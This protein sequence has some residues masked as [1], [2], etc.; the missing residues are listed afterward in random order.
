MRRQRGGVAV[1]GDARPRSRLQ[2]RPERALG[3][4]RHVDDHAQFLHPGQDAT[5]E[6]GEAAVGLLE[7]TVGEIVALIPRE[8]QDP[9][10]A[11]VEAV[12][13]RG[14]PVDRTAVLHGQ[15]GRDA[16][17]AHRLLDDL[18]GRR[19]RQDLLRADQPIERVQQFGHAPEPTAGVAR[20]DEQREDLHVDPALAHPRKVDVTGRPAHGEVPLA[21]RHVEDRVAMQVGNHRIAVEHGGVGRGGGGGHRGSGQQDQRGGSGQA[22]GF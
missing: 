16:A 20:V 8:T 10:P 7:G 2:D 22:H 14:I 3:E 18:H 15:H 13:I 9:H 6:R 1:R 17:A 21:G 4:M 11:R 19:R 5:A 12:E